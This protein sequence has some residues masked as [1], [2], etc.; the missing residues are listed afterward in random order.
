MQCK[1]ALG[2]ELL[3]DL[4][5]VELDC[6]F[7]DIEFASDRF[8]GKTLGGKKCDLA[9]SALNMSKSTR[10]VSCTWFIAAQ[11]MSLPAGR[12]SR[13]QGL[14]NLADEPLAVRIETRLTAELAANHSFHDGR[15]ETTMSRQRNAPGRLIRSN[16]N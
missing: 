3:V 10:E 1:S 12:G 2:T 7:G 11:P 5:Q 15:A 6:S 16:T 13:C 8:V 4:M 9:F 14:R